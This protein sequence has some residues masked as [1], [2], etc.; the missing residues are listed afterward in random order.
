MSWTVPLFCR[1][2]EVNFDHLHFSKSLE[3]FRLVILC[4]GS[5]KKS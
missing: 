4:S 3:V 5:A 1:Q 2:D